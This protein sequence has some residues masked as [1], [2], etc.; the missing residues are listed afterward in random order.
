[1]SHIEIMKQYMLSMG[2]EV[3]LKHYNQQTKDSLF[4]NL[5]YDIQNIS[6]IEIKVLTNWNTNLIEKLHINLKISKNSNTLNIYHHAL[7]IHFEAN[8]FLK[9]RKPK[10]LHDYA[11]FIK[12]SNDISVLY[13]D[14][15]KKGDY[16]KI[17]NCL[18]E[19]IL[20]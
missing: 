9:I 19:N 4:R 12:K 1:M 18:L 8:H 2:I 20:R 3:K 17:H 5:L 14:F 7:N 11:I 13:F 15:A 16:Q 6:G 10:S